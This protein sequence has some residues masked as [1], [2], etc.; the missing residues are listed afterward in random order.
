MNCPDCNNP[1]PNDARRCPCCG[2]QVQQQANPPQNQQTP[3]HSAPD[4]EPEL[5]DPDVVGLLSLPFTPI[6]GSWCLWRNYKTL[7]NRLEERKV[8]KIAIVQ[9]LYCVVLTVAVSIGLHFICVWMFWFILL[10]PW[11]LRMQKPQADF[12]KLQRIR[13]RRKSW[14]FPVLCG[15][16]AMV[17]WW[18]L[19]RGLAAIISINP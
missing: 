8:L 5:Y 19:C 2:A 1:L 7:G 13:Y 18:G 10:I 9:L 14:L 16:G 17:V 12:L 11:Y 6:F 3:C 15:S 4:G